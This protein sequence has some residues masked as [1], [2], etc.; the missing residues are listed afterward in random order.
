MKAL[1]DNVNM[2]FWEDRVC[3]SERERER[4]RTLDIFVETTFWK[5]FSIIIID[6]K[7]V[8]SIFQISRQNGAQGFHSLVLLGH[9]GSK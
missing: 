7:E 4:E 5:Y 8:L 2:D 9:L 1:N 6:N 3:D